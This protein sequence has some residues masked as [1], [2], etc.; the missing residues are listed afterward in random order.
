MSDAL[1]GVPSA[2]A[3]DRNSVSRSRSGARRLRSAWLSSSVVTRSPL[4]RFSH[5]HVSVAVRVGLD[6]GHDVGRSRQFLDDARVVFDGSEIHLGPG[7]PA[8]VGVYLARDDVLRRQV[9]RMLIFLT[10]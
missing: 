8:F 6:D 10:R 9:I 7:S 3:T 1:S 2:A 5:A 4:A